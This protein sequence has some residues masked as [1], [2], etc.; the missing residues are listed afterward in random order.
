MYDGVS[1]VGFTCQIGNR[2]IEGVVKEKT[3]VDHFGAFLTPFKMFHESKLSAYPR[4]EFF[5]IG[6]RDL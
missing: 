1:V 6:K 4:A 2:T 3:E 5:T